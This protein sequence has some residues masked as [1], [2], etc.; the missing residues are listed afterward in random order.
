[1]K[2]FIL[3]QTDV[4]KSKA[5]RVCFGIFDSRN[6]AIDSAKYNGLYC[7][8]AEVVVEEVTLNLF[9]EN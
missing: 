6:K 5:S 3:Y 1:M 4:W 9:E 2:L 7:S 8:C